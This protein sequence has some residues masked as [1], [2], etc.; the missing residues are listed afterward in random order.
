MG[1]PKKNHIENF[2]VPIKILKDL[3]SC[4]QANRCHKIAFAGE[5]LFHVRL[6]VSRDLN[7]A[8][9]I[10]GSL[11]LHMLI[12][13]RTRPWLQPVTFPVPS[14]TRMAVL[15]SVARTAAGKS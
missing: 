10:V 15:T 7:C 3:S 2:K 14:V 5:H 12:S 1:L 13:L 8:Q 9:D 6:N 4:E 11:F